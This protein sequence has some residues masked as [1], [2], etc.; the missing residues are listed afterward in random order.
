MGRKN[1]S[2]GGRTCAEVCSREVCW[3]RT[4]GLVTRAEVTWGEGCRRSE[5]GRARSHRAL[6]GHSKEFG[7]ILSVVRRKLLKP[8]S[9]IIKIVV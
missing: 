5:P 9:G 7:F 3:E 1:I 4:G 8:T 6:T 2:R